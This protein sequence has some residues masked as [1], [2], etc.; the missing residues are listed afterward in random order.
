MIRAERQP[1]NPPVENNGH[2]HGQLGVVNFPYS[3]TQADLKPFPLGSKTVLSATLTEEQ[4]MEA[5]A[6][7]GPE[8]LV[9]KFSVIMPVAKK[10]MR[11]YASMG[12]AQ[13][14]EGRKM[15]KNVYKSYSNMG[16][17]AKEIRDLQGAVMEGQREK[18]PLQ[19]TEDLKTMLLKKLLPNCRFIYPYMRDYVKMME[20]SN[21]TKPLD[22]RLAKRGLEAL[23]ETIQEAVTML[24]L[25]KTP[26]V[27]LYLD[28]TLNG[29]V[30]PL[31]LIG[32]NHI[33]EALKKAS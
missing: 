19:T 15:L 24:I 7:T 10:M 30:Q 14:R 18:S 6:L 26:E 25:F 20:R 23:E 33:K 2:D 16:E 12:L 17:Q 28:Y 5:T 13:S 3:G 9:Q 22:I 1:I 8:T 27:P 11:F 4:M 31:M 21:S 29:E 32:D